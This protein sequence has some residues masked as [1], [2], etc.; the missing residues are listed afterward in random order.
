MR[1]LLARACVALDDP[2]GAALE[3]E[4]ARE[5]LTA[6][7]APPP[8]PAPVAGLTPREAEVLREVARGRTNKAIARRLGVSDRTVDRHVSNILAKLGL[9]SRSAATAWAYEHGLVGSG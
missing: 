3:R 2:D 5:A 9:P 6:L 7:G 4:A 8:E 1:L